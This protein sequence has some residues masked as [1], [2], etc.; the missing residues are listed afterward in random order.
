MTPPRKRGGQ[1][2][3]TE[4]LA[5][6]ICARLSTGQSLREISRASGMPAA[7]TMVAWANDPV[8]YPGFSERY[9]RARGTWLEVIADEILEISDDSSNDYIS[10]TRSDGSN[11]QVLDAEHVQRSRLRVDS[12]KWLL[13]KLKPGVYGDRVSQEIS[14]PNGGD[15]P[16]KV[17]IEFV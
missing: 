9:A 15:I 12:R 17:T 5:T 8:L 1:S 11:E 6:D 14:G 10:R 7:S 4:E 2:K 13:S 3:Y 16:T